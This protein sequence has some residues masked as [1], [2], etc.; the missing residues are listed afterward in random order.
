MS[1]VPITIQ[2]P[3]VIVQV[4]VPAAV[5]GKPG[6][7][8]PPG[9]VG[10]PFIPANA[11]NYGLLD[12]ITAPTPWNGK[13][14]DTTPK[15]VANIATSFLNAVG[16][17]NFQFTYTSQAGCRFS[18]GFAVD[19]TYPLNFCYDLQIQFADP[20]QILNMELDLNQVLADG[21]TCIMDSQY[22]SVSGSV[23]FDAWKPTRIPGNPQQWG[24]S[25]HR[26]RHFWH[27][28][29]DGNTTTFDGAELDG[30]YT[31]A[32]VV[33]TTRTK[34]LGWGPPGLLL[35]NFQIEG[36]SKTGG[37]VNANARNVHVWSW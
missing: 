1:T 3:S 33:S 15:T 16:G 24:T 20:A 14:D 10:P 32:N 12:N 4:P 7:Q 34:A 37:N 26:V 28:S 8:G 23:E 17:R 29:A 13:W 5:P 35:I 25:W 2:L 21:R 27:R 19:L 11:V 18:T 22:A 31:A 6:I 36:S 30:V 9:P